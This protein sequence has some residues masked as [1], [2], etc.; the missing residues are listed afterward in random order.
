VKQLKK[1]AFLCKTI[2]KGICYTGNEKS[3][4]HFDHFSNADSN[5]ASFCRNSL[6]CGKIAASKISLS[7]KLA[8]CGM[9]GDEKDVPLTDSHFA[10]H[11]CDNVLVFYGINSIFFPSFSFVPESNQ[12]QFHVFSIP[13]G[14]S[15]QTI[16]SIKSICTN[17]SP[18]GASASSSVDLFNI[19]ILR[20]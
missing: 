1:N 11:C 5:V 7:G 19:C 17:V 6:L 16:A 3:Y 14:L 12:Q 20:I 10:S 18:P 8:S 15:L 13:A 4:F 9:E 2:L